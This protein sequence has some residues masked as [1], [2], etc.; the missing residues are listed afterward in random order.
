[1]DKYIGNYS[2]KDPNVESP[3]FISS[4]TFADKVFTWNI[5]PK[6]ALMLDEVTFVTGQIRSYMTNDL[7]DSEDAQLMSS[8]AR[9]HSRISALPSAEDPSHTNYGDYMYESCRI[10]STVYIRAIQTCTLFSEACTSAEVE[11]LHRVSSRV[12]LQTWKSMPGL[13]LFILLIGN[14]RARFCGEGRLSRALTRICSFSMAL[15]EWQVVVNIMETFLCVQRWIRER[16][17]KRLFLEV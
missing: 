6:T 12:P 5:S 3:L 10:A 13:W 15:R 1:M 14:P 17:S 4:G 2:V 11:A 8:I 16:G 7:S 9:I